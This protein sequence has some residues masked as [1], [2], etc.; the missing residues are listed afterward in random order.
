[1]VTRWMRR[2]E[3][4]SC[5]ATL[6]PLPAHRGYDGERGSSVACFL[7]ASRDAAMGVRH[8]R[9][10]RNL[11]CEWL[12]RPEI[13]THCG[14]APKCLTRPF[15]GKLRHSCEPPR[16]R[17]HSLGLMACQRKPSPMHTDAGCAVRHSAGLGVFLSLARRVAQSE[18]LSDYSSVIR[19]QGGPTHSSDHC[20]LRQRPARFPAALERPETW[21]P[22]SG[23]A[24]HDIAGHEW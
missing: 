9:S 5:K 1:M 22:R 7:T 11:A 4:D 18:K 3:H 21:P 6:F 16:R 20:P 24:K 13:P 19:G 10:G 8:K 17:Q 14:F 23:W 2:R 15:P 12:R